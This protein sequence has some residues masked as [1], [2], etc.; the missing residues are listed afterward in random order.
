MRTLIQLTFAF[1][2]FTGPACAALYADG[3][4]IRLMQQCGEYR[5]T[6]FTSPTPV[7]SGVADVSVLIQDSTRKTVPNAIVTVE[8]SRPD[9]VASPNRI[10]ATH[11]AA[12]NKLFQAALIEIP[13]PGQWNVRIECTPAPNRAMIEVAFVMEAAPPLPRWLSVWPWFGWPLIPI[14]LFVLH[15]G[16]VARP[17]HDQKKSAKLLAR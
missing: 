2:L 12:T 3:G 6:V 1:A 16:L 8:L 9:E 5:V 15:R 10:L 14:A 11:D 13:T 17:L 4:Q 7:R